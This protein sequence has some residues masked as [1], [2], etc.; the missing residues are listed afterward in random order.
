[1]VLDKPF[2]LPVQ[3]GPASPATS[4]GCWMG[5]GSAPTSGRGWCIGSIATPPAALLLARTP[6][7][8][9]ALAALFRESDVRKT[10]WAVV[11]GRPLPA[12]GRI[13]LP[14]ARIN[15]PRGERTAPDPDGARAI[16]DYATLDHAGR[17]FA[18]LELSP[19]TG[20]TH[21]LRAHCAAIGTPILG[22]RSY[23]AAMDF[24]VSASASSRPRAGA[25]APA[26]R[27]A[28]SGGRAAA[29]HERDRSCPW[30]C[31]FP[32]RHRRADP[33]RR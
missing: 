9:G 5:C 26:G 23:G 8:G 24:G 22:D 2:G 25:A 20:R 3:G 19:L 31:S 32:Q 10:Y 14:L 17:R 13:D 4:T 21:Q 33:G 1:M 28:G 16:T 7:I 11:A 18:W 15:G 12:A 6:G 29:A 30:L 27:H